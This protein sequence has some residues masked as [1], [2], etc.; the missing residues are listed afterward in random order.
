MLYCLKEFELL[1][2]HVE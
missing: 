1:I 2:F